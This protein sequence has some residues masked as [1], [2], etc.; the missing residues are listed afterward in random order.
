MHEWVEGG[1]EGDQESYAGSIPSTQP[2][3]GLDLITVR[4]E[5]KSRL[6]HLTDE[7]PRHPICDCL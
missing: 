3:A 1:A 4:S 5:L 6:D 2:D 7:P